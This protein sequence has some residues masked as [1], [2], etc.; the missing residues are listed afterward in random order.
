MLSVTTACFLKGRNEHN[1]A[2]W[3]I[4]SYRISILSA[5]IATKINKSVATETL[6][7]MLGSTGIVGAVNTRHT[8]Y[9]TR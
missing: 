5:S 2:L 4:K 1:A 3:W 7:T 9:T 6:V 8:Q